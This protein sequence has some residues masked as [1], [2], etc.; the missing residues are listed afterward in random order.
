MRV[1]ADR[2]ADVRMRDDEVHHCAHLRLAGRVGASA[3]LLV[4]LAPVAGEVA[5]QIQALAVLVDLDGQ[6][7]VMLDEAFGDQ[8]VVLAAELA[9]LTRH[10]QARVAAMLLVAAMRI[11]N[12]DCE[13]TTVSVHIFD[14]Q[15]IDRLFIM[16]VRPRAGADVARPVGQR[17][18]GPIGVQARHHVDH[19]GVQQM[20]DLRV[21]AVARDEL[22][23]V[24]Q[25]GGRGGQLG[26]VDVAVDPEGGLV[27]IEAG[28]RVGQ[29][30]DPDVAALIAFADRA[31]AHEI[32]AGLGVGE[33]QLRQRLVAV[34]LIEARGRNCSHGILTLWGVQIVPPPCPAPSG[35]KPIKR[36][37]RRRQKPAV[38]P[39]R[40]PP[41]PHRP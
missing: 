3:E 17:Q 1:I 6:A 34:E 29:H 39:A 21:A 9:R 7:V 22:V 31:H 20:R 35:G 41:R 5:V 8:A 16:R 18:L 30:H 26:G 4:F 25:A 23:Q 27:H 11:G 12:S 28:G 10:H 15:A 32:G 40:K 24:V 2:R 38:R 13:D 36:A 19:T 33:Q 37:Q 14:G